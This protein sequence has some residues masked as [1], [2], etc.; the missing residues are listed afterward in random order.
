MTA[1]N[2]QDYQAFEQML[3]ALNWQDRFS[4]CLKDDTSCRK[5]MGGSL[6]AHRVGLPASGRSGRKTSPQ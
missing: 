5:R 6:M 1:I 3:Q 2:E 4:I